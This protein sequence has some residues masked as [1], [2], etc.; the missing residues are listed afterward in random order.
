MEEMRIH[1]APVMA[2]GRVFLTSARTA[3]A[4]GRLS[5]ITAQRRSR[6]WPASGDERG[7]IDKTDLYSKLQYKM[8]P[9]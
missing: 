9:I 2:S 3:G 5:L 1:A 6:R 7:A 4:L 8:N